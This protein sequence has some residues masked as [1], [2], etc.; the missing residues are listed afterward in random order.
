MEMK[1]KAI[2]Q[3][4]IFFLEKNPTN[5]KAFNALMY[6]L[7]RRHSSIAYMA[8]DLNLVRDHYNCY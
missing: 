3:N 5:Y 4:T 1:Y 7:L 2:A 6:C 8:S